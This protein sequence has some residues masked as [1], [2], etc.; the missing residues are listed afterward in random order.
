MSKSCHQIFAFYII[1]PHFVSQSIG[2]QMVSK[3]STQSILNLAES[4]L[5]SCNVLS[6][7]VEIQD[8]DICSEAGG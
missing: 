8:F 5:H 6:P 2:L 7:S 3:E 4:V 1:L